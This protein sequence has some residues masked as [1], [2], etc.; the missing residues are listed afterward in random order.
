M[1]T[2]SYFSPAQKLL[3]RLDFFKKIMNFELETIP[4]SRF[5]SVEKMIENPSFSFDRIKQLSPCLHNLL[6]WVMGMTIFLK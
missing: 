5:S 6:M 1:K 2:I 3:N 4:Q